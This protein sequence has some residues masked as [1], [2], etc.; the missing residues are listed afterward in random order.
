MYLQEQH[1]AG[2]T[3]LLLLSDK[4][5]AENEY[6]WVRLDELV[7]LSVEIT[8][9]LFPGAAIQVNFDEITRNEYDLMAQ[10]NEPLL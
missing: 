2:I 3:N 1:L 4:K 8:Q 5:T 6:P 9:N 10:A 7:F